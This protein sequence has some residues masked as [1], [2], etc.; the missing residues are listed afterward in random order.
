[1]DKAQNTFDFVICSITS[2]GLLF[3]QIIMLC[4]LTF[5]NKWNLTSSLKTILAVKF[6]RLQVLKESPSKMCS[7]L[8]CL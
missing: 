4:Q 6:C 3:P 2:R 5:P 8:L 1:L 7:A